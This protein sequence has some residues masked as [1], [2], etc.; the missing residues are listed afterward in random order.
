[1][2]IPRGMPNEIVV[3]DCIGGY[4]VVGAL[5]GGGYRGV[6]VEGVRRVHIE[7]APLDT[8]RDAAIR[9]LRA[10]RLVEALHHPG[11][12]RIIDR[13]VLADRRPWMATEVPNGLG[14]YE[15]IARRALP[16]I[17]VA[18]LVRDLADVLAHAHA[19][20]VVH[21][22]LTLRSVVIA[23]GAR[24]F[25]LCIADWGRAVDLLSG[26]LGVYAAPEGDAGDGRVDIYALGVI[27]F[28]ATTRRF[29][30]GPIVD[31]PGVASGLATLIVQM[32]AIDPAERPTAA[33][34]SA[35]AAE[36]LA[37]Q[38][39]NFASRATLPEIDVDEVIRAAG[40]R[41][42]RPKWTPAPELPFTSEM[43]SVVS[44]E[45]VQKP[46]SR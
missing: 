32:L 6:E 4:R 16:A 1:M 29:P 28:R 21:R 18:G 10:S 17:E 43:A 24:D 42:A 3:G 25:P 30:E 45:I 46:R 5:A 7:V 38:R 14:L 12:A 40:P 23:T 31:V 44:G 9:M 37:T 33:E 34:V 26:E 27:A 13:G 20:G 39:D 35:L 36:L 8:W 22:A 11:I 19:H 2:H 15:L 41:F